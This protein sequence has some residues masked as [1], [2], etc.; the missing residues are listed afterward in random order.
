MNF[1]YSLLFFALSNV[2]LAK[3]SYL[4]FCLDSNFASLKKA[5]ADI[6]IEA[7]K[8]VNRDSES[9]VDI[10]TREERVEL[11]EAFLE[12]RFG[13]YN[14]AQKKQED[15]CHFTLLKSESGESKG[16]EFSLG[17]KSRISETKATAAGSESS[18]LS[19]LS[20]EQGFISVDGTRVYLGC[21]KINM[22]SYKV[23]VSVY[24][25]PSPSETSQKT[26]QM[27]KSKQELST[28]VE[29][30]KGSSIFLGEILKDLDTKSR[31]IGYPDGIGLSKNMIEGK[32]QFSL[33]L[34]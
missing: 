21:H 1:F 32:V 27:V 11:Y 2:L 16:Q 28:T 6:A 17:Q 29:M 12:H 9:C 10:V 20:G 24:Q 30:A 8:I 3:D 15:S 5:V 26:D 7:D 25:E 19:I 34:E 14:K 4:S 31:S 23:E 18:S 22:N 33:R 13:I